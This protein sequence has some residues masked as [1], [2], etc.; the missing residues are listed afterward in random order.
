MPDWGSS[1]AEPQPANSQQ[2]AN[3]HLTCIEA[4]NTPLGLDGAISRICPFSKEHRSC[5]SCLS[6]LHDRFKRNIVPAPFASYLS[7]F[8]DSGFTP[9]EQLLKTQ[10]RGCSNDTNLDHV[11][12][13]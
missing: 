11:R 13:L 3:M 8:K 2:T 6:E 5:E 1:G 9:L 10:Y 12:P 7:T 4:Y